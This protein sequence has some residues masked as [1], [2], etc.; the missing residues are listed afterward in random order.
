MGLTS[1]RNSSVVE[2]MKGNEHF[3]LLYPNTLAGRLAAKRA[4]RGWL[5]DCELDFNRQDAE[6]FWTAI[7]ARG[8]DARFDRRNS[9]AVPWSARERT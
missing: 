8:I 6:Q 7:D 1:S 3:M 2:A 4:V 5:L 9:E